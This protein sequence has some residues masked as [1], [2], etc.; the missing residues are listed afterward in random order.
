VTPLDWGVIA[1]GA[2]AIAFVNWYFL[3]SARR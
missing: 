1:L 3:F 2:A